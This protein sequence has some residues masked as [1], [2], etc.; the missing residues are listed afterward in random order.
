MSFLKRQKDT[1][2]RWFKAVVSPIEA[3]AKGD[4]DIVGQRFGEFTTGLTKGTSV[5]DTGKKVGEW[6]QKN[7]GKIWGS[8]ATAG[9]TAVGITAFNNIKKPQST[10]D[11]NNNFDLNNID[12]T[13]I[14]LGLGAL[15]IL[16]R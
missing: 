11:N 10:P 2:G 7:Y 4:F 13:Y 5:E 8:M 9:A 16:K 1:F 14:A 3:T 6:Q 12:P 15:V